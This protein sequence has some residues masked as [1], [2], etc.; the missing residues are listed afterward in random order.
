MAIEPTEE[1]REYMSFTETHTTLP[2]VMATAD[3]TTLEVDSLSGMDVGAVTGYGAAR[4]LDS[5]SVEYTPYATGAE[6]IEALR[7]GEIGV[8]V[9]LWAV[10]FNSGMMAAPP[11]GVTNA[12]ETGQSE[13]LS[14]GY[15]SSDAAL[16][17]ALDKA[18]ASA[19]DEMRE[20]ITAMVSMNP[21]EVFGDPDAFADAFGGDETVSS[22]A[23]MAGEIDELN[24]AGDDLVPEL[25]KL[26]EAV[27]FVEK[28][29]DYATEYIPFGFEEVEVLLTT[30]DDTSLRIGYS[31]VEDK[32][33]MITYQC[34]Y[35]DGTPD[36][37]IGDDLVDKLPSMCMEG[38]PSPNDQ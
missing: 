27:V 33:T 5:M 29:P 38:V 17:S 20:M 22:L 6:A 26:P 1:M 2:I 32:P 30:D 10:A 9:G 13:M 11:V 35:P 25:L 19:P 31:L 21:A 8:F 37:Y 36:S 34:A 14:I 4:W 24:S 16:G 18:L 23:G 7:S 15:A 12:G 3:G 28:H